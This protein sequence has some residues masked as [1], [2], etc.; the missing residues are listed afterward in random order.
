MHLFSLAFKAYLLED[1]INNIKLVPDYYQR[2]TL[3]FTA[4]EYSPLV[5]LYRDKYQW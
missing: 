4:K 2:S 5:K 1:V 3:T